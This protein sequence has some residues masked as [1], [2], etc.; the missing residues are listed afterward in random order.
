MFFNPQ[1]LGRMG[2]NPDKTG[3][4]GQCSDTAKCKTSACRN[5]RHNGGGHEP[6]NQNH[7]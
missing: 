5:A 2:A 4:K 7:A 3:A 1:R 6:A